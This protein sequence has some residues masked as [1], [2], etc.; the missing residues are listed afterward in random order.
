MFRTTKK[1]GKAPFLGRNSLVLTV[2]IA[3]DERSQYQKLV[4]TQ[5]ESG[6][7]GTHNQHKSLVFSFP[8][9]HKKRF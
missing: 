1:C 4:S 2:P 3:F 7:V 9:L 8:D 6:A 5:E